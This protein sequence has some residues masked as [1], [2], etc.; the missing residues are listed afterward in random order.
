[1]ETFANWLVL[2]HRI[3]HSTKFPVNSCSS[4]NRNKEDILSFLKKLLVVSNWLSF[5]CQ[6]L[7]PV[8]YELCND[9]WNYYIKLIS[10]KLDIMSAGNLQW[11]SHWN[12]EDQVR[13][14]HQLSVLNLHFFSSHFGKFSS[15]SRCPQ[16]VS[17]QY[18]S[19]NIGLSELDVDH[20]HKDLNKTSSIK[21]AT[22]QLPSGVIWGEKKMMNPNN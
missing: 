4:I 22:Y 6:E 1:V 11:I 10:P 5:I 12:Q 8:Y 17:S 13:P 18:F 15:T 2:T 21:I 7:F 20:L 19:Y 16:C 14:S 3:S 9:T